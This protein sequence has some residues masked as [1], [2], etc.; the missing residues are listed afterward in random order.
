MKKIIIL[1]LAII[2][3]GGLGYRKFKQRGAVKE[4]EG[5]AEEIFPVEISSVKRGK[6]Q[7]TV[8]LS[9]DVFPVTEVTL[10]YKVTGTVKKIYVEEGDRVKKDKLLIKI[11]DKNIQLQLQAS[12]EALRQAEV[13]LANTEKNWTRMKN[14]FK[15]EVITPY[16]MDQI[17]TKKDATEAQVK[18]LKAKLNLARE[19]LSDCKI[20]SPI[21][22]IVT[23]RFLD[24]GELITAS[25]M[26]KNDPILL[27]QD[28]STVKIKVAVG[29]KELGEIKRGQKVKIKVDAYSDR[30]FTGKVLKI[31]SFVEPSSRTTEIEIKVKNSDYLLKSGMFVRAEIITKEKKDVLLIPD[32]ALLED[33]DKETVF[34]VDN[35]RAYIKEV[36]TGLKDSEKT[37]ILEGLKEWEQVVITGAYR[38]KNGVRIKE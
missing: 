2:L 3:L 30:I 26:M 9:G 38:L 10:F 8:S 15:E 23:K 21:T 32:E 12:Q 4:K 17:Q 18:Q 16:E 5:N 36:E 35:N 7:K 31:G 22:G 29:E 1:V 6:I 20:Y 14:L 33:G 13:N 11:D 24:A 34:V 37:E 19:K 28:L 27:I 25:S